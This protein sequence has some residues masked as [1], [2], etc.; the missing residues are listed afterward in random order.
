M[1]FSE[2]Y[3]MWC[4]LI[5]EVVCMWCGADGGFVCVCVCV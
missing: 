2:T 5:T 1:P 3:F 4:L